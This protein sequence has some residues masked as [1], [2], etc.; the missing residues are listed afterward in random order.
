[1][2][3]ARSRTGDQIANLQV[4]NTCAELD[5]FTYIVV[6]IGAGKFGRRVGHGQQKC[7]LC[8]RADE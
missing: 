8:T 6:T 7:S 2:T 3:M 4:F 5:H 1:M